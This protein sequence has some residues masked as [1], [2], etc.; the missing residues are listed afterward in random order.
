[1]PSDVDPGDVATIDF[2]AA[3]VADLDDARC[4]GGTFIDTYRWHWRLLSGPPGSGSQ[5]L[6]DDQGNARV[7]IT[8]DLVGVSQKS[9]GTRVG[10]GMREC[11]VA[12]I[13]YSQYI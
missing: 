10:K 1:M 6:N 12:I 2:D 9:N 4:D 5:L 8:V 13:G 7:D 11:I 3:T